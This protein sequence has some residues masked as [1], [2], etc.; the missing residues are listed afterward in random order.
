VK[1]RSSPRKYAS[2]CSFIVPETLL[3][4]RSRVH[5]CTGDGQLSAVKSAPQ[6]S[7]SQWLQAT[8]G[9]RRFNA[10]K[11]DAHFLSPWRNFSSAPAVIKISASSLTLQH[12]KGQS[13]LF[14]HCSFA[15]V[16]VFYCCLDVCN[17]IKVVFLAGCSGCWLHGFQGQRV[18]G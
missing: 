18:Q 1:I 8:A 12:G 6:R 11:I 16:V 10:R 17:F 15:T 13:H 14:Q 3:R 7:I 4:I 5:L 2:I 9:G